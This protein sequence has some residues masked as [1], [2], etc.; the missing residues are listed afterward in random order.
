MTFLEDA[1]K[2]LDWMRKNGVR[3]A[4]VGPIELEID[5]YPPALESELE[6]AGKTRPKQYARPEDD[7]ALY[8]GTDPHSV[9]GYVE[10][11]EED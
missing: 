10:G 9:P 4:R 2:L 8:G 11:D 6:P 5:L 1:Q 7:P 3:S